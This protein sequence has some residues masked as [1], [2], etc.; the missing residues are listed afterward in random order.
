MVVLHLARR[1][2]QHYLKLFSKNDHQVCDCTIVPSVVDHRYLA[3]TFL[4]LGNVC[5]MYF[6]LSGCFRAIGS[7]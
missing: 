3:N 5:F 4:A 1:L 2:K 7:W 6:V